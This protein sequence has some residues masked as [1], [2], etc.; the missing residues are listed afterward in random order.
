MLH[1]YLCLYLVNKN[2]I[3]LN[4]L[5]VTFFYNFVHFSYNFLVLHCFKQ[6]SV[7]M[8][9]KINVIKNTSPAART[10]QFLSV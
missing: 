5:K 9:R 1:A 4:C 10:N 3:L 2:P 7:R 6:V 8:S